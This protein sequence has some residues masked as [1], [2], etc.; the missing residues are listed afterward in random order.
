MGGI[1][2][3]RRL[4]KSRI[5]PLQVDPL[6]T[7]DVAELI[8]T[9]LSYV[10][11][12]YVEWEQRGGRGVDNRLLAFLDTGCKIGRAAEHP[13]SVRD[14]INKVIEHLEKGRDSLA[15]LRDAQN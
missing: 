10:R 7:E 2:F 5:Q 13:E 9:F 14:R 8:L 1:Y 6:D 3:R 4:K 15:L 11:R 12:A